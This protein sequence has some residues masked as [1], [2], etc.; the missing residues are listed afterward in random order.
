MDRR[1]PQRR[2]GDELLLKAEGDGWVDR[3]LLQSE[4]AKWVLP[5]QAHRA[6][7]ALRKTDDS[8][9]HL[10]PLLVG[11][12]KLAQVALQ[13]AVGK[14]AWIRDGG[15]V[16]HRDWEPAEYGAEQARADVEVLAAYKAEGER[17]GI[18]E[19]ITR[20]HANRGWLLLGYGSWQELCDAEF[21][22]VRVWGT[23][24]ERREVVAELSASGLSTRAIGAAL[25]VSVGTVHADQSGV[26]NRTP[27]NASVAGLDGKTYPKPTKRTRKR[28][29]TSRRQRF[30]NSNDAA[31]ECAIL[32]QEKGERL[33]EIRDRLDFIIDKRKKDAAKR[34]R[35]HDPADNVV[36]LRKAT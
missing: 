8:P 36:P 33:E 29:T 35:R 16:R 31:E 10:D 11:Q 21:G 2:R 4:M 3:E 7:A 17:L 12:N 28:P 24:G 27:E 25:G 26:Q 6:A 18:P 14:G 19:V 13:N 20:M 30:W 9:R 15:R 34:K 23:V 22:G 1:S 32:E 5:G